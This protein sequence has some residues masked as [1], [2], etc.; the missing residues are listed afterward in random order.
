MRNEIG[1]V[2]GESL[3]PPKETLFRPSKT[4]PEYPF[5][6]YASVNHVYEMVRECFRLL[7]MDDCNFGQKQWNPLKSL[8][9]PGNTVLLKPNLVRHI[10]YSGFGEECLYTHPSVVA[11]ILDY[12]VIA[13]NG[14]GKIIV[15]DAPVQSC[16]F[17]VLIRESGYL[18]L[19]EYYQAKGVDICLLDFRNIRTDLED[20]ILVLP[21]NAAGKEDHGVVVELGRDSA[22]YGQSAEREKDYRVTCYDPDE[23]IKHH[24][25]EK[26]EYKINSAILDAD[27]VINIS[28]PKTHRKAGITGALKNLVGICTNKEYLPHHTRKSKQ[29]GGDEYKNRN[30]LI[31][32]AAEILDIKNKLILHG[33]YEDA[34]Q[35]DAL[36]RKL[37]TKGKIINGG[38]YSEGSWYGNDTIWRTI[39]DLNKIVLYADKNGI[40]REQKQRRIFHVGDMIISGHKEGPLLPEPI[41]TG[42]II[43][44]EDPVLF[45]RVVCRLMGFRYQDIP[46]IENSDIYTT[47]YPY[48]SGKM[49]KVVSKPEGYFDDRQ[50]KLNFVP[51][52]GW[53]MLLGNPDKDNVIDN[54]KREHLT[55]YIWGAGIHGM[56]S[57]EYLKR[58]HVEIK[59][60]FDKDPA[61]DGII[62]WNGLFC[63]LPK[64]LE[65][66]NTICIISVP[67]KYIEEVKREAS[68]L[69]F[70][71]ISVFE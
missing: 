41:N 59:Q 18:E 39:S 31:A 9:F 46:S 19:I 51:S 67:E 1:I 34:R 28:K 62:V 43:M 4:Y 40:M 35:L 13:L 5:Q 23:L 48:H 38:F 63:E 20:N 69:Q 57:A 42:V 47:K 10:N 3:Y 22:F 15:G 54:I 7:R 24:S 52:K 36:Y 2:K 17:D 66:Q 37:L 44:A 32:I 71:Y 8:V 58:R 53:E 70:K 27:V 14:T 64:E 21:K 50:W 49:E 45:D 33:E 55:V 61:K 16:D 30:E 6:E 65:E 60:F 26:H 12:V 68:C 56:Q 11:A 25:G 29:E